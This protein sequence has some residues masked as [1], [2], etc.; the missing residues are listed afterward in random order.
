MVFNYLWVK[1]A[2]STTKR[3]LTQRRIKT[4]WQVAGF[5]C[6]FSSFPLLSDLTGFVSLQLENIQ[7]LARTELQWLSEQVVCTRRPNIVGKRPPFFEV[8]LANLLRMESGLRSAFYIQGSDS[9][10]LLWNTFHNCPP[11]IGAP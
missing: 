6:H 11:A 2:L 8:M 3:I 10:G 4:Q 7:C 1:R 9:R 5:L